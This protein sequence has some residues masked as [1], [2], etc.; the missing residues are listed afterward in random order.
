MLSR[1]QRSSEKSGHSLE[2]WEK[3]PKPD[4]FHSY[5]GNRLVDDEAIY[6]QEE[7]RK[8]Q[9]ILLSMIIEEQ[10]TVYEEILDV[11]IHNKGGVFFLYGFGGT[12][13]T[14]IWGIPFADI[15]VL[16]TGKKNICDSGFQLNSHIDS[17]SVS[18]QIMNLIERT[19]FIEPEIGLVAA[20]NLHPMKRV[21]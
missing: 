16:A 19:P 1:I 6:N 9:K 20:L 15:R 3:L 18:G 2:N 14:F 11:V 7:Q 21:S 12:D 17:S 10:R 8:E 4:D 5:D 13:K